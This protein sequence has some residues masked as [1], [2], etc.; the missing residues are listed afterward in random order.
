M[1]RI[2]RYFTIVSAGLIFFCNVAP[3][4]ASSTLPLTLEQQFAYSAAVFRG[5]VTGADSFRDPSDNLIYTCTTLRVDE[6]LKG[7]LPASIR[8]VH[9]GGWVDNREEFVGLSPRFQSG[10]TYLV[11]VMR[12]DDGQ[13]TCVQGAASAMPLERAADPKNREDLI[14]SH[15]QLVESVRAMA[16]RLPAGDDVTD[17]AGGVSTKAVVGMLTTNGVTSRFI[18][19]DRGEPIPYIV[20]A[21]S[22]PAGI[23]LSTASNAVWQALNAWSTVTSLKFQFESYQNFGAGA[24]TIVVSDGKLRIQLHDNFNRINTTNVLGIGGRYSTSGKLPTVSWDL[25]GSVGT[26][27]FTLSTCG[28][29]VLERTNTSLQ[30]AQTLAEVL[31]HEI[32]HALSMAHSSE[33]TSSD[34]VITN[35]IMYF[36]AH[37][38]GRGAALGT[39]DPPVIRQAYP[40]NTPP[41][42]Y[43]RVMD[44]TTIPVGAPNVP[45]INEVE[46]RG[47]DLQTTNLTFATT[48]V[49]DIDNAFSVVGKLVKY[50]PVAFYEVDRIDPASTQFY[51]MLCARFSDGTNA[52]PYV[53]VRTM[54][55]NP[56][57]F[58]ASDGIPDQWMADYFGSPTPSAGNKSRAQDD[59]D[60]DGMINL[61]EYRTGM[62]PTNA[63]SAQRI[64]LITRTN[65]QFQ[66]MGYELYELHASTNLTHWTR[67]VNPILP[68]TSTG[69]FTGFSNGAPYRF[70]RVEKVP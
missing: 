27:D 33:V 58:G 61:R 45:G 28:F 55:F 37:A 46:M 23:T 17:Q 54:S 8:V 5:T 63:T 57:Q 16:S 47:Y 14:T 24:D 25:G 6:S 20:D 40:F 9:R 19:Q 12:Q 67:A 48:N 52:S 44:I 7:I 42:G 15:Q 3:S 18:Q 1:N 36:R 56:E 13:L 66:A 35:S 39:Y 41:W 43:D 50:T 65:I 31:C 10:G 69:T 59:F 32:G 21:T 30:N 64:T 53:R 38:D 70:F 11:F 26:N 22:L 2:S 60:G 51:D 68:T 4:L 29:V 49:S 34:P 62:N